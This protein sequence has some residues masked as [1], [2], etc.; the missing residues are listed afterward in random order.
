MSVLSFSLKNAIN[1]TNNPSADGIFAYG[2]YTA[3]NAFTLFT[4]YEYTDG[5]PLV[6][7]TFDNTKVLAWK[8]ATEFPHLGFENIQGNLN[9]T[10]QPFPDFGIYVHPFYST[11]RDDVGVRFNCPVNAEMTVVTK[12]QKDDIECGDGI[13]Y[14]IL[15]NGVEVQT[16]TLIPASLTPS[17]INTN[18]SVSE[19]DVLDFIVDVG[20]NSNSFCDDVALEVSVSLNYIKLPKPT[21]TTT[22]INCE[23]TVIEGKGLFV[24]SNVTAVLYN[25]NEALA[26]TNVLLDGGTY[27]SSFK[28]KDLNLKN[29]SGHQLRLRLESPA[30]SPSDYVMVN[31]G[32]DGSCITNFKPVVTKVNACDYSTDSYY[33]FKF[34]SYY[35]CIIAL[36]DLSNKKIIGGTYI[37][38]NPPEI[39]SV[40]DPIPPATIAYIYAKKDIDRTAKYKTISF[41]VA[42][43]PVVTSP[44][45]DRELDCTKTVRS[46]RNIQGRV[47]SVKSGIIVAYDANFRDSDPLIEGY[48]TP[49]AVGAI[50]DGLFSIDIDSSFIAGD[51]I[52]YAF[53]IE[54]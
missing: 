42:Q 31:V 8:G 6:L 34:Q 4:D 37:D 44:I 12:I 1:R 22:G 16:R 46:V 53:K 14:R 5:S 52:L 32:T 13:G 41:P 17:Q 54:Y 45:I 48:A 21:V 28:F 10:P 25:G 7:P 19:G 47:D 27:N 49:K 2:K 9:I 40:D 36:I 51:Y 20:D 18:I 11:Q 26:Y 24:P 39:I 38:Y 15:R 35:K 29:F 43:N 33:R 30:D 23:T 3:S 50:N